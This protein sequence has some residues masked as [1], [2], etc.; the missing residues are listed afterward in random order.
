MLIV[1]RH[2]T[3]NRKAADGRLAAIDQL[4]VR[5]IG[6]VLNG[7]PTTKAFTSYDAYSYLGDYAL[8]GR[9]APQPLLPKPKS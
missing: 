7:V 1:L 9:D 6:A 5:I 8:V 4:P 3:T 2:G